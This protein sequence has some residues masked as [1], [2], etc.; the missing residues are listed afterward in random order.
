MTSKA[1]HGLIKSDLERLQKDSGAKYLMNVKLG[2][3]IA[4]FSKGSYK[5]TWLYRHCYYWYQK[6]G[7]IAKVILALHLLIYKHYQFKCGIDLCYRARVG[8]GLLFQHFGGIVVSPDAV[9]GDNVTI[10]QCVTI[11]KNGEKAPII[12]DGCTIYAGAKVLGGITLGKNVIVGAN[13]VVL[14]DCPDNAIV[15]GVPAKIIRIKE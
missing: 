14:N 15:A 6:H 3:I 7:A 4:W 8:R 1:M 13:A 12:G 2:G 9:I 11:G 10:Y 5:I